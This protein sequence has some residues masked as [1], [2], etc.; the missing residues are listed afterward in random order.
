MRGRS[1]NS[2][3]VRRGS[4]QGSSRLGSIVLQFVVKWHARG[5]KRAAT[6]RCDGRSRVPPEVIATRPMRRPDEAEYAR[7][8]RLPTASPPGVILAVWWRPVSLDRSSYGCRLGSLAQRTLNR[9]VRRLSNIAVQNVPNPSSV[10]L[11]GWAL[12]LL[13][14]RPC[15]PGFAVSKHWG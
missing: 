15:L 14:P 3:G 13:A 5:A 6:G 11:T 9:I 12:R 2:A 4:A 7:H 10:G 1:P 8:R